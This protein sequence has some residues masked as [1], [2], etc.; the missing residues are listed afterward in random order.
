MQDYTVAYR[1]G[2]ESGETANA[3]TH[4]LPNTS[5][6]V[7]RKENKMGAYSIYTNSTVE[8]QLY[9]LLGASSDINPTYFP[10]YVFLTCAA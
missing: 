4:L 10:V 6:T 8:I 9:L 1:T 7:S 3:F 5:H 2:R